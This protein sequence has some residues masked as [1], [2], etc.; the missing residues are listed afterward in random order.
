MKAT[1][2]ILLWLNEYSKN[3]IKDQLGFVCKV[4]KQICGSKTI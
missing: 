4:H 2:T 1:H 3:V